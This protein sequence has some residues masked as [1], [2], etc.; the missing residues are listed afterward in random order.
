MN[1]ELIYETNENGYYLK[2]IGQHNIEDDTNIADWLQLQWN[3]Y[4]ILLIKNN[5]HLASWQTHR[6]YYFKN[7][8]DIKN[9]IDYLEPYLTMA[10]LTN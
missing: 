5:A 4:K 10:N 9:V 1:L 7:E 3:D 6:G 2:L 8:E